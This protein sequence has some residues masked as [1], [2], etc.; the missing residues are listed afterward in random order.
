LDVR[1][2]A[3]KIA[4]GSFEDFFQKYIAGAEPLPYQRV[5]ALAGLEL[6]TE[7]RKRPALGFSARR[8]ESGALVVRGV[9]AAEQTGL[10]VDDVI[11]SWNGAEPPR[12]PE[13][14]VYGQKKGSLLRL[15][16]RRDE[17]NISVDL[18][19]GEI[20]EIAYRVT[21]VERASEKAKH[22]RE[23]LLRG[24]TQPVTTALH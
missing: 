5:L 7:E 22:I 12:S 4:G 14:W 1:L 6:R 2:T 8:D 3:E 23:G 24:V 13:R 19:V 21:E 9:D 11:T 10:R 16:V 18:R 20:V 15:G 17:N